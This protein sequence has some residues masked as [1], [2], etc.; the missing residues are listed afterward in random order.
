[1]TTKI[2][3]IPNCVQCKMT[4]KVFEDNDIEHEYILLDPL[5][6]EAEAVKNKFSVAGGLMQMPIVVPDEGPHWNGF[7]PIKIKEL[8]TPQ[9]V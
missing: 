6:D 5:S 1:M 8:A 2:Y 3:S 9:E 4:K 7:N